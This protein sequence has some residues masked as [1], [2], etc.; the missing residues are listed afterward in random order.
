M[1]TLQDTGI[2]N[3]FSLEKSSRNMYMIFS[4]VKRQQR[5]S[6]VMTSFGLAACSAV[7]YHAGSSSIA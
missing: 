6:D 2:D 1:K 7:N 4:A 5:K 3:I